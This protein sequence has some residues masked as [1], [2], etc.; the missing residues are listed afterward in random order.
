MTRTNILAAL[1]ASTMIIVVTCARAE[2][3]S[4]VTVTQDVKACDNYADAPS[5]K[6]C[7][8]PFAKGQPVYLIKEVGKDGPHLACISDVMP[9]NRCFWVVEDNYID[10]SGKPLQ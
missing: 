5:G 1:A 3:A 2:S 4:I 7:T 8:H 6:T 10:L 9:G